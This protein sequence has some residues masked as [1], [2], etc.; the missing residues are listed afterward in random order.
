[1]TRDHTP[2][3]DKAFGVQII[4]HLPTHEEI[5]LEY[6][7]LWFDSSVRDQ[8]ARVSSVVYNRMG[9]LLKSL[10]VVLRA[11]PVNR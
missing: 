3:I 4:A 8:D 11:S 5:P 9:I 2:V 7:W 10:I 6:W 1:M